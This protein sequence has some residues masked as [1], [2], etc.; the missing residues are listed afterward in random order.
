M[1]NKESRILNKEFRI[2]TSLSNSFLNRDH[3]FFLR[4]AVEM[5]LTK[6]EINSLHSLKIG[7]A[8]LSGFKRGF[9]L[10]IFKHT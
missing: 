10:M 7:S 9:R 3:A 8:F 1:W 4:C 6:I 2:K 5:L